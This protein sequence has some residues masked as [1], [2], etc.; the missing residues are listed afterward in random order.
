MADGACFGFVDAA[1]F[2][3]VDLGAAAGFLAA[4]GGTAGAFT[5]L[6]GAAFVAVAAGLS[7]PGVAAVSVD[8]EVL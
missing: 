7:L 6:T 5:V 4:D 3:G 1:A 8:V 2:G